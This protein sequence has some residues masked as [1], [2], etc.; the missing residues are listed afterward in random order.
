MRRTAKAIAFLAG[1]APL[2]AVAQVANYPQTLPPNTVIGR[3]GISAGPSQA[4]PL[5]LL[6]SNLSGVQSA[7]QVYAGPTIGSAGLPSFR[8]LVGADLPL[9]APGILGGVRSWAPVTH[10]WINSISTGGVPASTQPACADVSDASVYC[11]ASRGQLP[12]EPSNGNASAGNVGE[13][14][15]GQLVSGSATSLTSGVNKDV[16]SISLTAGDWDVEGV[17]GFLPSGVATALVVWVNS[18]SATLP[19]EFATPGIGA[20]QLSFTSG[21]RQQL[22]TGNRRFSL[23]T[24]TTIYLSADAS[25][26]GTC[27]AYGTIRARRV[28]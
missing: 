1:F 22:T 13:F 18:T 15:Q 16:I 20:L 4:I 25:F 9:P 12:A 19:T 21:A 17:V 23:S 26:T 27:T 14:V 11:N 8:A 2:A 5:S 6:Q 10:Q 3:L 7:N 28:R 24:T